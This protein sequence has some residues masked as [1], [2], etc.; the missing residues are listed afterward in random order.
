MEPEARVD[1]GALD[2][3]LA[4]FDRTN[5]PGVAVGVAL[6]GRP[7]YRR[8][9]GLANVELPA[10]L[11]PSIRMRIGSTTKHFCCLAIMLLAEA[12]KLSIDDSPRRHLPE[13]PDWAE[14]MTLRQL[15][16]HTSGMR[17]SLDLVLHASGAGRPAPPDMQFRLLA[18]LASVNAAAGTRWS[19]NNGGYILLTTIVERVGGQPFAEFLRERIFEPIGMNDTL[20]RALDTDLLPNSATLHV[21]SPDGGWTRGV[22]G[23]PIGGEGGIAST[24]D[25][26]LR[27]LRHM[28]SPTVGTADTWAAMQTPLGQHG[29]GFGLHIDTFQGL[30]RIHHGGTVVGGASQMLKMPGQDLDVVVISNGYP[31]LAVHQLADAIVASCLPGTASGDAEDVPG[32]VV[33]GSFYSAATGRVLTLSEQEGRQAMQLGAFAL[34]LQRD[35]GGALSNAILS[36]MRIKPVSANGAAA[37]LDLVEYG[38]QDRLDRVEPPPISAETSIT[39]EYECR[40]AGMSAAIRPADGSWAMRLAGELGDVDYSLRPIGATLWQGQGA[41]SLPLVVTLEVDNEG[42]LMT[43]GRTSRLRFRRTTTG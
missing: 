3:L 12:G 10:T 22:F 24:I 5:A 31:A 30:R 20:V 26:M 4:P 27:W 8:G 39:G 16:A 41:S 32:P 40:E 13:L 9:A 42:F 6:R 17:D 36:D 23:T 15:M 21:P 35:A 29:Y 7:A 37:F 1:I 2:K 14:P 28:G 38:E 25:D 18:G 43:T 34:P 19:Y 11:S 33:K